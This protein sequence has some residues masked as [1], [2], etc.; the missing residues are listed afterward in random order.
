MIGVYGNNNIQT[1]GI[2][3]YNQNYNGYN[4]NYNGYNWYPQNQ[5]NNNQNY[6]Y[7]SGYGN[8]NQYNYYWDNQF[9]GS[10]MYSNNMYGYDNTYSYQN[11]LDTTKKFFAAVFGDESETRVNNMLGIVVNP[12][13]SSN[14]ISQEEIEE[15]ENRRLWESCARLEYVSEHI[16]NSC[17]LNKEYRDFIALKNR[18]AEIQERYITK[19]ESKGLGY[20]LNYG[21]NEELHD[22][23]E[24]KIKMQKLN[25]TNRYNRDIFKNVLRKNSTNKDGTWLSLSEYD[26]T[27]G[28]SHYLSE[29]QKTRTLPPD[30][31]QRSLE[32]KRKFFESIGKR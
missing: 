16:P 3:G 17:L 23:M 24:E 6:M 32:R 28:F 26:R 29:E 27:K 22:T 30:L 31:M 2:N 4:Q 14:L 13:S 20:F 10:P 25:L 19:Y 9:S 7:T 1:F 11:A 12:T 15:M 8:N 21:I 18:R 5:Y